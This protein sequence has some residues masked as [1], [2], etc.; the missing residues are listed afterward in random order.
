MKAIS[1]LIVFFLAL[2]SCNE[3]KNEIDRG[4]KFLNYNVSLKQL[5]EKKKLKPEHLCLLIDKSEYTL[6]VL[7]N[8][9]PI[10]S[11]PVVLGFDPVNDKLME[12]DGCTPE[13]N[14][15]I[16]D[17]YPHRKWSHFIWLNYPNKESWE[18]HKIAK[19]K[20]K[21][22]TD[23]AI[24]GDVGIHGVPPGCDFWIDFR[25]NWTLGCIS[26]KNKDIDELYN[27]ISL[28]TKVVIQK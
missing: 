19:S 10:K 13:G 11:Y 15:K 8:G 21:I 12:G 9:N 24:G 4:R 2:S 27:S 25:K 20:K 28:K 3:K 16:R 7:G 1:L 26:L 18:K 6:I 14:F 17:M 5:I 23:V 22:R